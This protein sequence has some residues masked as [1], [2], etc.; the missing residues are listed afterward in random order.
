MKSRW[1]NQKKYCDRG[2]HELDTLKP[3][4]A[5]ML[6]SHIDLKWVPTNVASQSEEARFYNVQTTDSQRCRRNIKIPTQITTS[7]HT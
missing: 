7:S 1:E 5:V 2:T 3:G 6:Q 4:E